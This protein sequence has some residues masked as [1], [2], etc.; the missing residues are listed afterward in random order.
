M[1]GYVFEYPVDPKTGDQVDALLADLLLNGTSQE[2]QSATWISERII[3]IEERRACY[4]ECI[5]GSTP[6]IRYWLLK[7]RKY[8]LVYSFESGSKTFRFLSL[9]NGQTEKQALDNA[10]RVQRSC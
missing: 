5:D 8:R 3:D 1:A 9:T 4:G 10:K 7:D 6:G 2:R